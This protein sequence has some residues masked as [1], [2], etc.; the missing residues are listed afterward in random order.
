MYLERGQSKPTLTLGIPSGRN[1]KWTERILS[2][3]ESLQTDIKVLVARWIQTPFA[4]EE[5]Q[6]LN[7]YFSTKEI[8]SQ[9]RYA[10]AMRNA[11]IDAAE[12]T[13][14]L[15]LDDD[16]VPEQNL[17][18]EALHLAEREPN[19]VFQGVPYKVANSN[20]RLARIEGKLYE[21]GYSRY[22]QN[23]GSVT[24]LDARLM[25]A[26][27]HALRETPFDES[28]V[29][30][31]GEGR[32]LARGL[33]EKGIVLRLGPEL[34]AAHINRDTIKAVMGQKLAH[35]RGRGY[36]LLHEGPGKRGWLTYFGG[37][38]KRHF[39]E[40]VRDKIRGE[41]NT[42]ELLYIWGTNTV[43]WMGVSEQMVRS[44]VN[45]KA[46]VNKI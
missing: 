29:F 2:C 8:P 43:F 12:S 38:S 34:E 14:L 44:A 41:L 3:L 35:G 17:L 37:Y 32:E 4:L 27:V 10:P 15:F 21:R 28:L 33:R 26:P 11:I 7:R 5:I 45:S 13:H 30:G 19:T 6:Q 16:M 36:Q 23:D 39:L 46:R 25:L 9:A 42:E 40:P 31:G 1:S 24:L 20:K 18:K 22:V